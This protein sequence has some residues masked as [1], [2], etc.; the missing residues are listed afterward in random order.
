MESQAPQVREE[1]SQTATPLRMS[2]PKGGTPENIGTQAQE[3]SE[4]PE[5]R[6]LKFT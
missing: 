1:P 6:T 4:R 2:S 5:L 3:I